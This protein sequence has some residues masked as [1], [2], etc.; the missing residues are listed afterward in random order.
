MTV[1]VADLRYLATA[2]VAIVAVAWVDATFDSAV[3]K[4]VGYAGAVVGSVVLWLLVQAI[5]RRITRK[6]SL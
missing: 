2:T 6:P 4:T 1:R 3:Q 5:V